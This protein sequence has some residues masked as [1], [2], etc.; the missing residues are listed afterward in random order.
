M[1]GIVVCPKEQS[2]VSRFFKPKLA[3]VIV[4]NGESQEEAWRRH[5]AENPKNAG[6]RI[7]IFHFSR[8][9][10]GGGG[11]KEILPNAQRRRLP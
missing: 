11:E 5:L 4:R 10:K 3:V 9:L 8:P 1:E 7:R 6:T 2:A